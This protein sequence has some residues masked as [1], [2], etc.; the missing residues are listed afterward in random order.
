M[1]A[2]GLELLSSVSSLH[3]FLGGISSQ[4]RTDGFLAWVM[5]LFL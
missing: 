5:V 1:E 4:M 2:L 3:L